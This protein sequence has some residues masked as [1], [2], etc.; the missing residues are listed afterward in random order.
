MAIPA[1]FCRQMVSRYE[2]LLLENAGV[3]SVSVDGVS[4]SY[5]ELERSLEY[6]NRKLE[7]AEGSRRRVSQ[8]KLDG[9]AG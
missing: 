7:T 9:Y 2:S 4:V 8:I 3:S 1:T 6:W 5:A